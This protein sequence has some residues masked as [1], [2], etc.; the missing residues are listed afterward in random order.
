MKY[1]ILQEIFR[2][3]F[4]NEASNNNYL[5]PKYVLLPRSGDTAKNING[6]CTLCNYTYE[7]LM[8]ADHNILC[9]ED[10]IHVFILHCIETCKQRTNTFQYQQIPLTYTGIL[11]VITLI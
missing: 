8:I 10:M 5:Q 7:P 9:S 1:Y 11:Q 6:P 3:W 2:D 4:Q